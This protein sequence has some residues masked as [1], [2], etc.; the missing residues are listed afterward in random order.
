[1]PS[2]LCLCALCER[3]F[4]NNYALRITHYALFLI[5]GCGLRFFSVILYINCD[6]LLHRAFAGSRSMTLPVQTLLRGRS[7]CIVSYAALIFL[8]VRIIVIYAVILLPQSPENKRNRRLSHFNGF[9]HFKA[10]HTAHESIKWN[11]SL[12]C[13]PIS[14]KIG[15]V[16]YPFKRMMRTRVRNR[17]D[18]FKT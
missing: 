9:S 5:S 3:P 18:G 6:V 15:Q 12:N 10:G 4:P 17:A 16:I 14:R 13:V 1:M 8:T 7:K 2:S 11:E